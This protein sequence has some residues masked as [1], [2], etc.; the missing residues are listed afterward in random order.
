MVTVRGPLAEFLRQY[1]GLSVGQNIKV[2]LATQKAVRDKNQIDGVAMAM[3]S[4]R[5][6][7]ETILA[8]ALDIARKKLKGLTLK[9]AA[10]AKA[11]LFKKMSWDNLI[12]DGLVKRVRFSNS[13]IQALFEKSDDGF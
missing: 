6:I 8:S 3:A 5:I 11:D 9:P 13:D 12:K 4:L 7:N 1:S 10:I 2:M